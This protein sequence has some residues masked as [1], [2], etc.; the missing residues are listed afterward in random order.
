MHPWVEVA[1][2]VVGAGS[3]ERERES[4]SMSHSSGARVEVDARIAVKAVRAGRSRITRIRRQTGR[5]CVREAPCVRPKH[6]SAGRD[7]ECA[8]SGAVLES[9]SCAITARSVVPNCNGRSC[10]GWGC[11]LIEDIDA[12][13][14]YDQDND[15]YRN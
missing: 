6:R 9:T 2:V 4:G 15:N 7:G 8:T 11:G 13:S 12:D 10:R 3:V 14:D 1:I 5:D